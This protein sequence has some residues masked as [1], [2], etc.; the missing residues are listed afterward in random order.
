[1]NKL[2]NYYNLIN[3]MYMYNDIYIHIYIYIKY[4]DFHVLMKN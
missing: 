2:K 1:M 4:T 3:V